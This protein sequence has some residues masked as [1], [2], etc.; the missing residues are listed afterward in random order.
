MLSRINHIVVLMLENRSFDCLLGALY[1][2]S[3]GFDGLTGTES[4]PD[5]DGNP[6]QVWNSPG[7]DEAT[8]SIPSPDPGELWTDMNEQLFASST[9]PTPPLATMSG[10][11][12]NYLR[13]TAEPPTAKGKNRLAPV[14]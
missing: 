2:K 8:M 3:A 12:A 5:A 14:A 10:F 7:A 11:V 4:N 6:V 1:P 9:A 13:Q